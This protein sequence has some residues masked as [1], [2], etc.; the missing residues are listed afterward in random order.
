MPFFV[1]YLLRS[2]GMHQPQSFESSRGCLAFI[3]GISLYRRYAL[4]ALCLLAPLV[5]FEA[6]QLYLDDKVCSSLP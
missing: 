1:W 6:S 3:S 5:I 2:C 4:L